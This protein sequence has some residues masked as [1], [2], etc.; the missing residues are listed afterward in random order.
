MLSLP[1][2]SAYVPQPEYS[3]D[4]LDT[5]SAVAVQLRTLRTLLSKPLTS[6][7][8]S[9]VSHGLALV[10]EEVT[11]LLAELRLTGEASAS[12]APEHQTERLT[13]AL[14]RLV[15]ERAE[16][17]GVSSRVQVTGETRRLD[18]LIAVL[19]YRL[20]RAALAIV[21]RHRSVQHVRLALHYGREGLQL[22]LTDDGV[23]AEEETDLAAPPFAP[24]LA[25]QETLEALDQQL[26]AAGGRLSISAAPGQGHQISASLPY[27]RLPGAHLPALRPTQAT[28]VPQQRLRLLV[29]AGQPVMRAGLR[30][31][32]ESYADLQV[33]GEATNG[34]QA[35]GEALE[36]GPQVV[37]FDLP[38]PDEQAMDTLRQM[39]QLSPDTRILVLA[40]SDQPEQLAAALRAGADGYLLREVAPDELVQAIRLVAQGETI[41]QRQLAARLLTR[42]SRPTEDTLATISLTARERQVLWLLAR[43]LRNKEIARRL[44]VSERTVNFHLANIYQKLHVSGR[45]EALSRAL[46]AGLLSPDAL[47]STEA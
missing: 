11:A 29:V 30:R 45:T 35:T 22:T 42:L 46:E 8:L 26:R 25:A 5:L 12:E 24:P 18:P 21:A 9:T 28:S 32:L 44:Q 23:S 20:T 3:A 31:L 39:K 36:L 2:E 41:V 16:A 7:Q 27:E 40:A 15:E 13:E 34:I 33:I 4:L 37:I 38:R 6:E 14:G 1:A 17:L 43:G 47:T 10:E 19:L